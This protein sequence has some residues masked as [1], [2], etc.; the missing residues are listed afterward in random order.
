MEVERP[1]EDPGNKLPENCIYG[2]DV[3]NAQVRIFALNMKLYEMRK[4]KNDEFN[5][6]RIRCARA[7]AAS[8][9]GDVKEISWKM[10]FMFNMKQSATIK[11]CGLISVRFNTSKA[12]SSV[13]NRTNF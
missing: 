8:I 5:K 13:K 9:E 4:A 7:I 10:T 12:K 2:E 3:T 11:Q 1:P 6:E